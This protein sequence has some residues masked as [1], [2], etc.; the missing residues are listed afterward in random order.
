MKSLIKTIIKS[1]L[2]ISLLFIS[3]QPLKAESNVPICSAYGK[4][5]QI[6]SEFLLPITVRDLIK[7]INGSSPEMQQEIAVKFVSS[8]S[9]KE[10]AAIN[11]MSEE[12]RTLLF[13]MA[14]VQTIEALIQGQAATPKSVGDQLYQQCITEGTDALIERMRQANTQLQL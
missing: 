2:A 3:S 6:M 13:E 9:E 1:Q 8:M 11:Q 5:G 4:V 12:N 14:G 7:F 10:V